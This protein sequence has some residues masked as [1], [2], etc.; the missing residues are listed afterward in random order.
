[1]FPTFIEHLT[2][3]SRAGV[4]PKVVTDCWCDFA[5]EVYP[6]V[7]FD[8]LFVAPEVM[9]PHIVGVIEE[10]TASIDRVLAMAMVRLPHRG[11]A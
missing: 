10:I 6:A 7:D 4:E 2:H 5:E 1:V 9:P 11:T 8:N 3:Y